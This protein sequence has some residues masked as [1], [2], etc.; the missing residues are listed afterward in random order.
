MNTYGY[1][2]VGLAVG[3]TALLIVA[4]RIARRKAQAGAGSYFVG[5]RQFSPLLV[6][7]C[8]TGLFSG[9]TFI[10]VLEL[11]YLKG[12]SAAWYGVAESIQVVLIGSLVGPFRERALITISGLIGDR[13]GRGARAVAGAITAFAFP[14]WSVATALAF[15]S[16]VH[17]STGIPMIWSLVLTAVLLLVYLQGGG[18]WSIGLTQSINC[19]I[20]IVMLLLGLYAVLAGAGL[21]GLT[22]LAD[23]HPDYFAADTVGMTQ[24]AAWFGTFIVNVPLA[25]ATFQMAVSC[26]TPSE[27]RKGLYW[28]CL[29]G[30]PFIIVATLLGL[31]AAS[32][33]PNA[34]K[35]LIAVPA[36]L[37]T[38]LPAPL[39]GVFF[40]GVWACA[41]GWGGPCQFSGATSLGRD[42]MMAVRPKASEMDLVR[43]TRW[44]LVVLTVLMVIFGVLR[45]EQSA[46]WN[47]LAWTVRN[48]ATFAPVITALLWRGATRPA[49]LAAMVIGFG[50][51]MLWYQLSGWGVANFLYGIHPVWLG[52]SANIL[53]LVLVSLVTT[54]DGWRLSEGAT[55]SLGVALLL[56]GAGATALAVN[57]FGALGPTGLLGLVIFLAALALS[58]GLM[59]IFRPRSASAAPV[60]A[61]PSPASSHA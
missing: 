1:W 30:V 53:A 27:G 29:F 12:V 57:A 14:M 37:E 50:T 10:A 2:V 16:A 3:Y 49:V 44:A 41:L 4:A 7:L 35:G 47:I 61:S 34:G 17:V 36:Y 25:Q 42:V 5:G 52:M 43:Y 19:C 31:A 48:S 23:A 46:W 55:F 8:V 20:F 15:A 40:L 38:V 26:R 58:S 28:A 60:S 9:S 56:A 13:Y 24:I 54:S 22:E 59:A 33:M 45:S 32:A 11:S 51:G 18:M 39:V 6:A 21:S